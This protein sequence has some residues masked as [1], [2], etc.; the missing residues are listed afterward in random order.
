LLWWLTLILTVE[1]H[2][3]MHT[4][5]VTLSLCSCLNVLAILFKRIKILL[6]F[7]TNAIWCYQRGPVYQSVVELIFC[8]AT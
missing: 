3:R 7:S 5:K 1:T 6:L 8:F 4:I 2:N